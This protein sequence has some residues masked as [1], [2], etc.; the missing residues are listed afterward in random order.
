M[1]SGM[2][3]AIKR[4]P[5]QSFATFFTLF[6][7]L[8]LSLSVFLV[9]TFLY[10][11]L[12]Y[13]ESRPQVTVYF[14]TQTTDTDIQ[15]IKEELISSGKVESAKFIS[16]NEAYS[17]YKQLNKDNPLLLEMVTPDILPASLEIYAKK[18]TYLPEIADFLNKQTGIDEVNF[19]KNIIEKL[20]TLTSAVRKVSVFFFL[21]FMIT[22]V[23]ILASI[24]HFKIA[25]KK[26]EIELLQLLG[27]SKFYIKK[28][29]LKEA[30]FFGSVSSFVV[31]MICMGGLFLFR[32]LIQSYLSGIPSLAIDLGFYRLILWPLSWEFFGVCL[33]FTTLFGIII[34]TT[35]TLLAT[36]KY[37]K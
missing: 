27:A 18:P 34:S 30:L 10:G 1:S 31:V 17:I 5:Y 33:L 28:P 11:M 24:T 22:T 2:F 3:T 19:Q 25:L 7:T 14:Q 37:I 6:L 23:I 36:Q 16:K 20:L 29:F 12:G 15:K 26:D 9:L 4:T 32:S 8:F 35:S 21:Y 13:V